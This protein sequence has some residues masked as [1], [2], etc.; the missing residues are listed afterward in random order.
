MLND[1][2]TH[3]HRVR[4]H[5]L[6]Q[7]ELTIGSDIVEAARKTY[8]GERLKRSGMRWSI[9]SRQAVLMHYN[10]RQVENR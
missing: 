5:G 4:Y 10:R 6:R 8:A 3:R 2:R 7:K 1:F 9:A